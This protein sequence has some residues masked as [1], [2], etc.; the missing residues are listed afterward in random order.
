MQLL[1][2]S[3]LQRKLPERQQCQQQCL[4]AVCTHAHV[5]AARWL[6]V[7]ELCPMEFRGLLATAACGQTKPLNPRRPSGVLQQVHSTPT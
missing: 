5:V 7:K 1:L 2:I 4:V 6:L 3:F